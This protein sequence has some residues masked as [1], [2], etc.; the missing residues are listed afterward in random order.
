MTHSRNALR[1]VPSLVLLGSLVAC[2]TTTGTPAGTSSWQR[3]TNRVLGAAI[4]G[5]GTARIAVRLEDDNRAPHTYTV[6]TVTDAIETTGKEVSSYQVAQPPDG[7]HR[8][9]EVVG[10]A[11]DDAVSLLV[12]VRVALASPGLDA[13]ASGLLLDRIDALRQKLDH[14][15]SAVTSAPAS[16]G[17]P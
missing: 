2:T 7:L 14:L 6:V 9:N 15:D 1:V 8:A 3:S 11:L 16:I 5:L 13:E 10:N 12:D 4:S 17:A